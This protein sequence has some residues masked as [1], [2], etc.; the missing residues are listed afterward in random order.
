[1]VNIFVQSRRLGQSIE[2]PVDVV[3]GTVG[4]DDVSIQWVELPGWT[5]ERCLETGV[6]WRLRLRPAHGDDLTSSAITLSADVQQVMIRYKKFQVLALVLILKCYAAPSYSTVVSLA[7]SRSPA[8]SGNGT[9]QTAIDAYS[10]NRSS[11]AS[12]PQL[13][14][15]TVDDLGLT[16]RIVPG[17]TFASSSGAATIGEDANGTYVRSFTSNGTVKSQ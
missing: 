2:D 4:V 9:P 3:L 10:G 1:M 8:R 17:W 7:G 16:E 6:R 13:G 15:V 12:G 14:A 5:D 11:S